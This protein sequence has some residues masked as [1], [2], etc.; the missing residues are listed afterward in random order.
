MARLILCCE[1]ACV[2]RKILIPSAASLLNNLPLNPFSPTIALPCNVTRHISEMHD[3]PLISDPL[4]DE[5]FVIIVPSKEGLKLFL[6]I[7]GIFLVLAG[8]MVG[9]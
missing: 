9:G 8:N 1:L 2:I 6:I 4:D 3:I 7:I 5:L